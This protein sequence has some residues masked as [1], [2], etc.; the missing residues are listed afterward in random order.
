MK[1]ENY[2]C[3][4]IIL[5]RILFMDQNLFGPVRKI[6]HAVALDESYNAGLYLT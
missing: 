6:C 4:V 3:N 2:T 5:E 1:I